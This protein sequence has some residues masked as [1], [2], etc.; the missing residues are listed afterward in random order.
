MSIVRDAGARAMTAR[1]LVKPTI[2][3]TGGPDLHA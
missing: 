1:L 2:I 3:D